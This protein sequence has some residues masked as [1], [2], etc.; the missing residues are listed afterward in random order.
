MMPFMSRY[1]QSNS[2]L[3]GLGRD[4]SMGTWGIR[5]LTAV[6]YFLMILLLEPFSKETYLSSFF[7]KI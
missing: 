7:L 4:V 1:R 3:L 5:Y 6:V 2:V